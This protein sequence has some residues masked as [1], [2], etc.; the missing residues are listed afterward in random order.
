[1]NMDLTSKPISYILY[2]AGFASKPHGW[3]IPQTAFLCSVMLYRYGHSH[4][5]TQG[6]GGGQE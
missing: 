5:R 6:R 4:G 1:M 3:F 2:I